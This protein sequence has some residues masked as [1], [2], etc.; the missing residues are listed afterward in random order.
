MF[1]KVFSHL[2][3]SVLA[4]GK[5]IFKA[6]DFDLL[7]IASGLLLLK[8]SVVL[9][10]LLLELVELLLI[11]LDMYFELLLHRNVI[12]NLSLITD[13]EQVF[14]CQRQVYK[15]RYTSNF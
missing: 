5:Q 14:K 3:K 1:I 7:L 10:D 6:L 4:H 11:A 13:R 9:F 8:L 2:L 15:G 12:A